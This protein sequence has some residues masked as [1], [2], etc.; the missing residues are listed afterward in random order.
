MINA[1][2]ITR[3]PGRH[4]MT[5]PWLASTRH[6]SS[7]FARKQ[8]L[9]INDFV[10][11]SETFERFSRW[12]QNHNVCHEV[13]EFWFGNGQ[14]SVHHSAS[15]Y[16]TPCLYFCVRLIRLYGHTTNARNTCCFIFDHIRVVVSGADLNHGVFPTLLQWSLWIHAEVFHVVLNCVEPLSIIVESSCER[17]CCIKTVR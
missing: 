5:S 7:M 4:V 14:P 8:K 17:L 11:A 12:F 2:E 16:C 15:D 6:R 1:M 13:E 9:D 10:T 3:I